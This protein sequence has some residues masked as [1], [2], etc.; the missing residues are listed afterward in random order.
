MAVL[1]V[2]YAE[3]HILALYAACRYAECRYDESLGARVI[4]PSNPSQPNIMFVGKS[5]CLP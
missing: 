1:T 4:V 5:R 2:V 3:S